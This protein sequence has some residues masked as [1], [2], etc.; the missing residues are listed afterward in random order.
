MMAK[1]GAIDSDAYDNV[2]VEGEGEDGDAFV[3]RTQPLRAVPLHEKS[4]KQV[5]VNDCTYKERCQPRRL[6]DGEEAN[7][8][9]VGDVQL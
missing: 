2:G 8:A 9:Q 6:R 7:D 1:D 5:K 3:H 4:L